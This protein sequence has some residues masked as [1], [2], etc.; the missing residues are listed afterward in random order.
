[1]IPPNKL[2]QLA[3]FQDAIQSEEGL[4]RLRAMQYLQQMN[5]KGLLEMP[6]VTQQPIVER[7]EGGMT[8]PFKSNYGVRG[9]PVLDRYNPQYDL[10]G[11]T[12]DEIGLLKQKELEAQKN[13][14]QQQLESNPNI[15]ENKIKA[16][17]IIVNGGTDAELRQAQEIYR[18]NPEEVQRYINEIRMNPERAGGGQVFDAAQGLASLGRGGDNMLLH[19]NPEEL[20]GLSSILKITYNPITGLPEAFGG[21]KSF[22]KPFKQAAKAVK[23]VTKSKAF[24]TLAP[25]AL[26]IAAPYLA[27]SYFPST[28]GVAGV[29]GGLGAKV[30]AM[31]PLAFGAAT[32]IGSGLGALAAGAKPKDALQAAALGGVSAGAMRGFTN[33]MDPNIKSVFGPTYGGSGSQI[34]ADP[35]AGK[36]GNLTTSFGEVGTP[37]PSFETPSGLDFGQYGK[38]DSLIDTYSPQYYG[39]GDMAGVNLGIDAT[40]PQIDPNLLQT[41]LGPGIDTG[42]GLTYEGPRTISL[43]GAIPPSSSTS[44]ATSPTAYDMLYG[45]SPTTQITPG[46]IETMSAR[47][48]PPANVDSYLTPLEYS[49]PSIQDQAIDAL[50]DNKLVRTASNIPMGDYTLGDIG[51]AIVDDYSTGVG[52]GKLV[53]TDAM[54]PDYQEQYAMEDERQRQLEELEKLGYSVDLSD[55]D[56]GFGQTMVIR[57]ASGT[58]M[59]STLSIQDILDIAYGRR[60]RTRLVDRIDYA[61]ATAK[62][63][64]LVN[65]AHGGG[66]S[67]KVEGDGHG[68]ED[69]VYMPIKEDGKQIGTL[70]VSPSE[71]VVDAYTMS[72]LGNGNADEGAKVM[73]GVVESVRKKAYGTIRQ[74]KEIDGLMA[75]KPMM[76]GV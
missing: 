57:D 58:V 74:P 66:F 31:G 40:V 34:V 14:M 4:E 73:D 26:T 53:A 69:N 44:V 67:G 76:A 35:T 68:M 1:M 12:G 49:P 37:P 62:H 43:G 46:P 54:I 29:T 6:Q 75:L 8:S 52:L 33:Y 38:V 72:A 23:K 24:R 41:N 71:Y 21:F 15:L 30:A 9:N 48:G 18:N 25:L 3:D 64:G 39:G 47:L 28:F 65:L 13:I 36:I 27:A 70:A 5:N 59:P 7:Q 32:G 60:P 55:A 56:T 19:I 11:T 50:T 16:A 10:A 51:G 45:T 17:E 20:Q 42:A 61:P 22:F 63:G 2:E